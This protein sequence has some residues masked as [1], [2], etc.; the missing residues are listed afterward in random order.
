MVSK[1]MWVNEDKEIEHEMIRGLVGDGPAY[2]YVGFLAVYRNLP[3]LEMIE[4]H[5]E[6]TMLPKEPS[7]C[8]AV[9]MALVS[10]ATVF[11]INK[12]ATYM[13]RCAEEYMA[14]FVKGVSSKDGAL[15]ECPALIKWTTDDRNSSLFRA[16]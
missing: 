4:T 5:P 8:V 12:L 16:A 1:I 13:L 11:N 10:R 14:L 15:M 7:A 6:T 9:A 3:D 2:E